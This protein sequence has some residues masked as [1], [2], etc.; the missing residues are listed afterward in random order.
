[1]NKKEVLAK[2]NE[3]IKALQELNNLLNAEQHFLDVST[4][5]TSILRIQEA[6]LTLEM[7]KK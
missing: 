5:S 4:V 6:Y 2:K 1:M 3:V 7:S